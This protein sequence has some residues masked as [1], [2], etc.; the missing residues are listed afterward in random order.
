MF[1]DLQYG[2]WQQELIFAFVTEPHTSAQGHTST[3][4]DAESVKVSSSHWHFIRSY[5]LSTTYVS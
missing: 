3:I 1:W 5:L 4:F 2:S